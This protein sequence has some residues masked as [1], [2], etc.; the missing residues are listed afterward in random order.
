MG[1]NRLDDCPVTRAAGVA[2]AEAR[3]PEGWMAGVATPHE[4]LDYLAP[5]AQTETEVVRLP[6]G[7]GPEGAEA[8]ADAQAFDLRNFA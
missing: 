4:S 7:P 3:N 6:A 1:A 2:V 5:R 8:A